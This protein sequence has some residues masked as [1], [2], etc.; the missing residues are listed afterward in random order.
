MI[1]KMKHSQA[2]FT[3]I[4]L[5]LYAGIVAIMT[6][7]ISG[8]LALSLQARVK[9]QVVES[10]ESGSTIAMDSMLAAIRNSDGVTLTTDGNGDA[11]VTLAETVAGVHPTVFQLSA[12]VLTK[13][14]GSSAAVPVTSSNIVID[15]FTATDTTP[16]GETMQVISLGFDVRYNNQ[17]PRQEYQYAAT[18]N[19]TAQLNTP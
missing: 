11:I 3:L 14:E 16:S 5:L 15:H 12:G 17:S 18:Y 7:A 8:L 13:K 1:N 2:G 19:G 10:V 4:E 6:T 9:N